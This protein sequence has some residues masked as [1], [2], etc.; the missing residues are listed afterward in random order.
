M[1]NLLHVSA[2]AACLLLG[3]MSRVVAGQDLS[4]SPDNHDKE[5]KASLGCRSVLVQTKVADLTTNSESYALLTAGTITIPAGQTG[6][7]LATFSAESACSGTYGAWCT[8]KISRGAF[9]NTIEFNPVQSTNYAFDAVDDAGGGDLWEGNS[10]QRIS[11]V[12]G[13]GTYTINVE[14]AVVG[15]ATFRLDDWLFKVEFW[16]VS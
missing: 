9:P 15:D 13:A 2:V 8:V 7:L 3:G 4:E 1:K 14:W 10:M 16:R 5:F 11:D 12:L 6:Y